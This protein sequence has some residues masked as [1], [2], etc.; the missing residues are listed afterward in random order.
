MAGELV[1]QLER[2]ERFIAALSHEMK[3]PLT[4]MMGHAELIRSGRMSGDEIML[5]AQ[6]I[7]KEGRRLSDMS[8]RLLRMVLLHEDAAEL[9]MIAAD[10]LVKDVYAAARPRAEAQGATLTCETQHVIVFAD[11]PLLRTLLNNLMDNALKS[12]ASHIT[13]KAEHSEGRACLSVSDDGRGMDEHELSR[14]T[15]P[16][17][18]V[19]KSRARSQGGAGLGLALCAEIAR[20]HG[21]ELR[22]VSALGK[23]TCAML[24]MNMEDDHAEEV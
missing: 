9:R 17:Y 2:R 8:E 20:I 6:Y 22:F 12:G 15:E 1:G 11:D 3:T 21:G 24:F 13:L 23:G 16:F 14:I 7:F 5:A 19:D 10:W 18:R 4:A